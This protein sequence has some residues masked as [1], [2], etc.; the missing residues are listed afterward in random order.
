[1]I[2]NF[3][4]REFFIKE[5]LIIKTCYIIFVFLCYSVFIVIY[6]LFHRNSLYQEWEYLLL[7]VSH[8]IDIYT[9]HRNLLFEAKPKLLSQLEK[10]WKDILAHYKFVIHHISGEDNGKAYRLSRRPDYD[11]SDD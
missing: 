7:G 4:K 3:N 10:R 1:V 2:F 9:D 8:P 11:N 6:N 5:K